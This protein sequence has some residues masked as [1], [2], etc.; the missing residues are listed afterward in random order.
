M[1]D[2]KTRFL[3]TLVLILFSH[4]MAA[5]TI[6][7]RSFEHK[8]TDIGGSMQPILDNAGEYCAFIR[9]YV[10]DTT[11]QIRGNLGVLKRE[12]STNEIKIWV[13]KGTK[14]LTVRHDNMF[15]LVGYEIP[16]RLEQK[17]AYHAQLIISDSETDINITHF[18]RHP[19]LT[20][21]AVLDK[22]KNPCAKI[23]FSITN[24]K[25]VE[26]EPDLG[27]RKK[28]LAPGDISL[29]VPQG[30]QYITVK[31]KNERPLKNYTIPVPIE[32][33]GVY[34]AVIEMDDAETSK[35][36]LYATLGYSAINIIGPALTIG[37]RF[38]HHNIEA[39]G[40]LGL[41]RSEDLGQYA[42]FGAFYE[43]KGKRIYLRYGYG[44]NLNDNTC[45]IPMAG[46]VFNHYRGY[47]T[48]HEGVIR[49][50][51][52]TAYSYSASGALRVEL[53]IS[54]TLKVHITPEYN[55]C[56]KQNVD[57]VDLSF[58][59]KNIIQWN[60]GFNLCAGIAFM[61]DL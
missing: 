10:A 4:K 53:S 31:S 32:A 6:S 45:I 19:F 15:P 41:N 49:E 9:F 30:T 12:T 50:D 56:F 60:T 18:E 58:Y 38:N 47:D 36:Q 33:E 22:S 61:F 8:P 59:S 43:Y 3:L 29:Y 37:T 13:P 42:G 26:I 14:R 5:Q 51:L 16:V 23:R 34:D 46:L 11:F 44:L 54:K 52:R 57:C 28:V 39:G 7:I 40:V 27:V 48:V 17:K 55:L 21:K 20:Q 35:P 24:E 2:K 25:T 1:K